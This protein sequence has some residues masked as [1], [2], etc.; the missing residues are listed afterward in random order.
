M[1]IPTPA[2]PSFVDGVVVHQADLNA[3]ASNLT[4]LYNYNQGG[5][6]SQRPACMAIQTVTQSIA[7]N[8]ASLLNFNSAP[9]N[10]GTM[11]V[12]SVPNQITI[13]AAG[14]YYIFG[15]VRYAVNGAASL[16]V[17]ARGN[18]MINGTNPATNSV[19]NTDVPFM[20]AG[21]GPTAAAWFV[22][23]LAA[24]ATVYLDTLQNTGGA[25]STSLLYG[26]SFLSCFYV[27]APA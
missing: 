10:V 15:Q 12:A 23:N 26:G 25:I 16:G 14:I 9:V 2:I 27:A 22:A 24:G 20:T 13:Q 11:W 3:L 19:S 7:N 18:V 21:N 6:N 4:N 8:T 17:I 1:G 5:F